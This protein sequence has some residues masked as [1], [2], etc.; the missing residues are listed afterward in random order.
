MVELNS[1]LML[2]Q[3]NRPSFSDLLNLL[4]FGELSIDLSELDEQTA[5][6]FL[7][8]IARSRDLNCKSLIA[9]LEL[10]EALLSIRIAVTLTAI[11]AG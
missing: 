5:T 2:L 6:G 10:T 7:S 8:G 3:K 11:G 4:E 9:G 1:F